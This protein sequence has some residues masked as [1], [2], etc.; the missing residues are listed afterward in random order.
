VAATTALALAAGG[1][2]EQAARLASLAA[3]V[4]VGRVGT[5]PITLNELVEAAKVR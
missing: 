3:A 2:A 1:D 4:V 5:V